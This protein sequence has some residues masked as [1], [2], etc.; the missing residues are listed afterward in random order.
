MVPFFLLLGFTS[1]CF[2]KTLHVRSMSVGCSSCRDPVLREQWIRAKYERKEFVAG[3]KP[4]L[5]YLS[6]KGNSICCRSLST[7]LFKV[8]FSP[9]C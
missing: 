7:N 4:K 5:E 1:V 2:C 8:K 9:S 3:D 6:G